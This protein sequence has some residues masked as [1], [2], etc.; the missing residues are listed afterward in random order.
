MCTSVA[1][2]TNSY[3]S[4]DGEQPVGIIIQSKQRYELRL[5]C[6]VS[7]ISSLLQRDKHGNNHPSLIHRQPSLIPSVRFV[8]FVYGEDEWSHQ[9]SVG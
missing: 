6:F 2:H 3:I 1:G 9:D 8:F 4:G 5:S 7:V